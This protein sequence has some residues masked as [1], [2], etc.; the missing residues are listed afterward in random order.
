M[1]TLMDAVI[2][3][4][5]ADERLIVDGK[6]AKNKIVELA[7]NLDPSLIKLLLSKEQL[8]D[9][10]FIDVDGLLVFD[11]IA[12][13]RFVNNK[14]F[15]PDSFTQFKNKIGLSVE[16]HYLAESND[17]V[18]SWAYSGYKVNYCSIH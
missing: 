1:K 3:S 15:L 7:L 10:F 16:Q 13:Q 6:L 8:K 9:S 18:L 17:V 2:E 4:V 5:Q 14:S 12:F 11:K